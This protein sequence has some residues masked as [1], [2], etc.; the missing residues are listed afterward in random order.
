[1]Y[2]IILSFLLY[3]NVNY[4]IT[5]THTLTQIQPQIPNA[6]VILHP[7]SFNIINIEKGVKCT[8]AVISNKWIVSAAHCALNE[9]LTVIT[10]V[11]N[12]HYKIKSYYILSDA[13]IAYIQITTKFTNKITPLKL[14]KRQYD[15]TYLFSSCPYYLLHSS[16]ILLYHQVI[17][18][19]TSDLL[20]NKL[21]YNGEEWHVLNEISCGG[22]SGAPLLEYQNNELVIISI[23]SAIKQDILGFA[24]QEIR[25]YIVYSFS[26]G[27]YLK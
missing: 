16:R 18:F 15:T 23:F 25:G 1:M 12:N 14:A 19:Y 4:Q 27:K 7:L 11:Y 21:I 8:G 17:T 20:P 13:D 6:I 10:D 24:L 3:F 22:D 9:N 5:S 26:V 2:A